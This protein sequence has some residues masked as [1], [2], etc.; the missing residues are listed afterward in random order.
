MPLRF[1]DRIKI[2][3]NTEEKVKEMTDLEKEKFF[4]KRT[5]KEIASVVSK[6]KSDDAADTLKIFEV[7]KSKRIIKL[8]ASRKAEEITELMEFPEDVAG[9]LM[10]KEFVS[11]GKD[12]TVGEAIKRIRI[13]KDEN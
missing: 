6:M 3:R 9:S 12:R 8:I 7:R 4:E 11:M 1:F 5:I 10:Q 2:F 13:D